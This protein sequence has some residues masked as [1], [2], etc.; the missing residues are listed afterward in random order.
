MPT[1]RAR[2]KEKE[3]N[4]NLGPRTRVITEEK[5]GESGRDGGSV[6]RMRPDDCEQRPEAE[7]TTCYCLEGLFSRRR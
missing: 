7:K 2:R 3:K 5:N 4:P 1:E 6:A